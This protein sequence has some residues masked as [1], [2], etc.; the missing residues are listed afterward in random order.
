MAKET[1]A[2]KQNITKATHDLQFCVENLQEALK[3]ASPIEGIIVL[4]LIK[5]ATKLR[6]ETEHFLSC[7]KEEMK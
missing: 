5:K 4:D 1:Y 7:L 2:L 3:K 6:I